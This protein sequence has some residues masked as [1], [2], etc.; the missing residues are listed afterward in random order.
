MLKSSI[1]LFY[2]FKCGLPKDIFSD[3]FN[4]RILPWRLIKRQHLNESTIV[5]AKNDVQKYTEVGVFFII[6]RRWKDLKLVRRNWAL[7]G[8]EVITQV[9]IDIWNL[10]TGFMPTQELGEYL[11]TIP[12]VDSVTLRDI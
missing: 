10:K 2:K 11:K 4:L 12:L 8:E 7:D 3:L 6:R 5:T 1:E 9:N